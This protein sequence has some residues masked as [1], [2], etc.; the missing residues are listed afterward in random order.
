MNRGWLDRVRGAG[1]VLWATGAA[2]AAYLCMYAFRK[3][4]A[5]A[6]YDGA[7]LL[8][9][10]IDLKTAFL[11]SQIVGYA[12]SKVIGIK[13]CSEATRHGRAALLVGLV[14]WAELA[15]VLFAVLPPDLKPL[16]MF[17]N[18]LPLGMVWGLVVWYLEGRR[19]SE[20]LLAGLSCAFIVGSG[21]VKD[22]GSALLAGAARLPLFAV[23]LPD[24]VGAVRLAVGNPLAAW[25]PIDPFWM[26]AAAGL[27]FL[28]PFLA[29]VALLAL[30]PG[31]TP[32]DEAARAP[33]VPMAAD[34][35][36]G[37]LRRFLPGLALL[38]A[39]FF[40]LTAYRDYRDTFAVEL[41]VALGHDPA[42]AAFRGLFS[43]TEAVVAFG[44]LVP[45]AL[46][47]LVRDNRW[48]LAGAF[49][50]MLAGT[51]LL[52]VAGLL[53]DAGRIDGLQF[54]VLTGLGSYLAYVPFGAVLFDRMIAATRVA[55]T[56]VFAI[57]LA[58]AVGYSGAVGVLLLKDLGFAG[59]DRLAFFRAFTYVLAGVG[60]VTLAL[61]AAYFLTRRPAP[62]T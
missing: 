7:R 34:D 16:A 15:L 17:L 1:L 46:L 25:G 3:P 61:A 10:T 29:A 51:A 23:D 44:V 27:L 47:V 57:Y 59:V 32:A 38:L 31:P 39:A 21:I 54:M 19:T 49:A 14:V 33:R 41:F 58:D 43:R 50:I 30:L 20:L 55:G 22:V 40:L 24:P 6:T 42:D 4:F 48:G 12:L 28:P 62:A 8:G 53:L 37:F 26:P 52:A 2:F 13:V 11:V 9:T 60:T 18:G 5:A 35:R 36:A 45:L 56:A